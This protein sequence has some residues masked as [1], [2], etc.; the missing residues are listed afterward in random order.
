MKKIVV[1]KK[2]NGSYYYKVVH[3]FY[4]DY[5]LGTKNQYEHEV[6][7]VIDL[8]YFLKNN[9]RKTYISYKRMLI[10]DIIRFLDKLK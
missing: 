1:W 4:Q 5:N 8:E 10:N 7:L 6:C 3:G 2:P 9:G